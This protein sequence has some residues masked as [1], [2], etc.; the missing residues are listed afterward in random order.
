[1]KRLH[2]KVA[3]IDARRVITGSFNFTNSAQTRN[4]ENLLV[5][6]S[7]GLADSYKSNWQAHWNHSR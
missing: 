1:M 5:L 3:V 4:A 7:K 2:H 6:R